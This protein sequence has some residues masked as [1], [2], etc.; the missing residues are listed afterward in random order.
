MAR[1]SAI[2]GAMGG[3]APRLDWP[4][5]LN[6]RDLGGHRTADGGCTRWGVVVRSDMLNRM[7]ADAQSA[8]H[9]YG[10]RAVVDLRMPEQVAR[11][12]SPFAAAGPHGVAYH[13]LPF[14]G[15]VDSMLP[16]FG[17]LELQYRLMISSFA[18]V[19]SAALAAIASAAGVLV[20]CEYGKDRTGLV[21]ALLLD[22][23]GV[24]RHAVADDYA[25][26]ADFLRP[27][28][29]EFLTEGPGDRVTREADLARFMPRREVILSTLAYVDAQLGG[30]EA[31]LL[32]AGVPPAILERLRE[33]LVG[34]KNGDSAR[35]PG[36]RRR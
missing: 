32:G 6:A 19:A 21:S 8:V 4:G 16:E 18:P 3:R 7:G 29:E 33:R 26:S 13:S 10:V 15:P 28:F 14:A 1:F 23:A 2:L 22:V 17:T 31:Y 36:R 35:R 34:E 12:P 9:A 20:H 24:P 30:V 25:E 5:F 11:N 27:L